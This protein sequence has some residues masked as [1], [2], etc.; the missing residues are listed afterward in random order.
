MSP[1]Q[2]NE[3]EDMPHLL[4]LAVTF[5]SGVYP[6]YISRTYLFETPTEFRDKKYLPYDN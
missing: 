1:K 2:Y 5:E 6:A 3:K 4:D